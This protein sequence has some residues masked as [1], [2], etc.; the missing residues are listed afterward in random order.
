MRKEAKGAR[1][2]SALALDE[3]DVTTWLAHRLEQ[4]HSLTWNAAEGRVEARL[5]RRLGAIVLAR[6]PDPAPDPAAVAALLLDV[7]RREGLDALPLGQAARAA[8]ARALCRA[9]PRWTRAPCSLIWRTGWRRCS[10]AG[11]IW[12]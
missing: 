5:E 3:D 7:V 8:H 10:L 4:R 6:V 12:R 11:A 1:I 2:M 9:P